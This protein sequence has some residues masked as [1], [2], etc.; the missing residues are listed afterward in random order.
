MEDYLGYLSADIQL[1]V[2]PHEFILQHLPL[3]VVGVF[4]V[5]V[6]AARVD[7]IQRFIQQVLK[8]QNRYKMD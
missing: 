2:H 3:F 4:R 6:I 7:L 5:F 1:T 8:H